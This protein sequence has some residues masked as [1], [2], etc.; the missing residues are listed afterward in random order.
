MFLT[1]IDSRAAVKG[2]RDPL[3]AGA[4][5]LSYFGWHVV[6]NLTTVTGSM[7]GFTTTLLGYYFAGEVREGGRGRG[8]RSWP[9]S[10]VRAAC[11]LLAVGCGAGT[12][13]FGGWSGSKR[14]VGEKAGDSGC[15]R[16]LPSIRFSRSEALRALGVVLRAGA[17]E[18]VAGARWAGALLETR[19][20]V[21]E[22]YIGAPSTKAGFRDA[23]PVVDLLRQ[24]RGDLDLERRHQKLASGARSDP[25]GN[26]TPRGEREFYGRH[27]RDGGGRGSRRRGCRGNLAELLLGGAAGGVRPVSALK[28]RDQDGWRAEGRRGGRFV[29]RLERIDCLES[30]LVPADTRRSGS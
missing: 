27:L 29:N 10:E 1:E 16:R 2:S 26:G 15:P 5:L 17:G 13:S 7:R 6:G 11:G 18:W 28:A 9:S 12:M 20:F 30:V 22:E 21:V 3:R 8:S 24:P 4:A 14:R 25:M 19:E 23:R